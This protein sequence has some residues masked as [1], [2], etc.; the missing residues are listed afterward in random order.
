MNGETALADE[1]L[2]RLEQ[3]QESLQGMFHDLDKKIAVL[4]V[5][6]AWIAGG[7]AFAGGMAAQV[8]MHTVL[9]FP[10]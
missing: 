10:S 6:V 7:A 5:K 3:Q 9:R 4:Q 8:F 2:S 1:R